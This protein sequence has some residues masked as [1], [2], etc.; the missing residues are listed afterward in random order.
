MIF[1]KKL[2]ECATEKLLSDLRDALLNDCGFNLDFIRSK[3]WATISWDDHQ[4]F[5]EDAIYLEQALLDLSLSKIY[6]ACIDD[7]FSKSFY[8][9]DVQEVDIDRHSIEELHNPYNDMT[10]SN[11]VIFSAPYLEFLIFMPCTFERDLYIAG[12]SEFL[13]CVS[14]GAGWEPILLYKS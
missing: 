14:K 8:D 10:M 2:K 12:T 1:I 5:D 13:K 7:I 11:S 3:L 6:V 4:F 9:I